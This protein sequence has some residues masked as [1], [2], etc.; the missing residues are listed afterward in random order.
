MSVDTGRRCPRCDCADGHTQCEHCKVCE[1]ARP[2]GSCVRP[3]CGAEVHTDPWGTPVQ[4]P[5]AEPVV[6]AD[7]GRRCPRCDCPDGHEQCQHC[8][9]C[10]HAR[11]DETAKFAAALGCAVLHLD[12]RGNV[13][14]CPDRALV[15]EGPPC[16]EVPNCDGECCDRVDEGHPE[17]P[18]DE[19]ENPAL[20]VRPDPRQPAYDAVYEYIRNLGGYLPPDPVHRNAVIW[21]AVHAALGATP[22]GRCVSSHC[23]ED[24]HMVFVEGGWEAP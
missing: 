6:Q 17:A 15:S 14:P 9:V 2:T 16:S 21:R 4:C 13:I 8:K 18:A 22:V 12:P 20:P 23:V 7:T 10:P 19:D 1:H 11:P 5:H 3:E 24:D